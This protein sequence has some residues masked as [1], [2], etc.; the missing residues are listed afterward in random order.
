MWSYGPVDIHLNDSTP[1]WVCSNGHSN[2]GMFAL[3]ITVGY[4]ILA[5]SEFELASRR[6]YS[7]SIV[8]AAMAFEC[9]LSRLFGKWTNIEL[10]M[11]NLPELK[12][13]EIEERLRKMA[14]IVLPQC[15]LW[16]VRLNQRN[17]ARTAERIYGTTARSALLAPSM[18][19]KRVLWKLLAKDV[20]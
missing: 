18:M 10:G 17:C 9:E 14:R 15:P 8:F 20:C 7:M 16:S 11:S 4:K 6:D 5:K 2:Q 19:Q 12:E 3:E 1:A 13:V